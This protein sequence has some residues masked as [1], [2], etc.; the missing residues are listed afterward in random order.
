MGIEERRT[1]L[2]QIVRGWTNTR[3]G[4]WR[5]AKSHIL[6]ITLFNE[7]FKRIGYPSLSQTVIQGIY[8]YWNKLV[9]FIMEEVTLW[10]L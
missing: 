10:Q 4:Y 5:I 3:K 2:N 8:Y 1:K 9:I 6:N 7:R